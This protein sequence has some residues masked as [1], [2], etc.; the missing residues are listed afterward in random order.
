MSRKKAV[1]ILIMAVALTMMLCSVFRRQQPLIDFEFVTALSSQGQND[2]FHDAFYQ[3]SRRASRH[4]MVV[5]LMGASEAGAPF[6]EIAG[7]FCAHPEFIECAIMDTDKLKGIYN[8]YLPRANKLFTASEIEASGKESD[9]YLVSETLSRFTNPVQVMPASAIVQDPLGKLEKFF[10][11]Q[12]FFKISGFVGK[13]PVLTKDD[14]K[15]AF[16]EFKVAEG[17]QADEYLD[18]V[19][20]ARGKLSQDSDQLTIFSPFEFTAEANRRS[21]LES[22]WLGLVASVLNILIFWYFF[23]SIKP[24]LVTLAIIVVSAVVGFTAVV[25]VF[26]NMHV[27]ALVFATGTLGILEEYCIHY[28]SKAGGEGETV[29]I[30]GADFSPMTLSFMTTTIGFVVTYLADLSITRQLA[31]FN[32][33]ALTVTFLIV[34]FVLPVLVP[35]ETTRYKTIKSR[36]TSP[37]LKKGWVKN[38]L[39]ALVAGSLV[40]IA[41]KGISFSDDPRSFYHSSAYLQEAKKVVERLFGQSDQSKYIMVK[42]KDLQALLEQEEDLIAALEKTN[43]GLKLSALSKWVPS[44]RN[45]EK[46]FAYVQTRQSAYRAINRELGL[47]GGKSAPYSLD[48]GSV[49]LEEVEALKLPSVASNRVGQVGDSEYSVVHFA[50]VADLRV[51]PN[52]NVRLVSSLGLVTEVFRAARVKFL[53]ILLFIFGIVSLALILYKGAA[54]TL[55]ILAIPVVAIVICVGALRLFGVDL[56]LFHVIGFILL[57]HLVIDYSYFA[58]K[59][60]S[61]DND[62]AVLGIEVSALTT[63]VSFGLLMFSST[64]AAA[65]FGFVVGFGIII[66]LLWVWCLE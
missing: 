45:Q 61:G 5:F 8:F 2:G 50:G 19:Q 56:T 48:Q 18:Y 7:Q 10:S 29:L 33:V 11:S 23:R 3:Y 66:A 34:K 57:F 16:F 24:T 15:Y 36:L 53:D 51:P 21:Q 32:V 64:P 60:G 54:M 25:N 4:G 52:A 40:V 17:V 27:L 37:R 42:G 58:F 1:V 6:T 49:S 65:G 35:L 20:A 31:I 44:M 28:F 22:T 63:I 43:P 59:S 12:A 38:G 62:G 55:K 47:D 14:K 46:S 26:G 30:T 13:L 41:C 39:I 9:G